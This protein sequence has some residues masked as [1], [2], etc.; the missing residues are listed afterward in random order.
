MIHGRGPR[1]PVTGIT[2]PAPPA[3]RIACRSAGRRT[4]ADAQEGSEGQGQ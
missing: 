1:L 2:F 3:V 4:G